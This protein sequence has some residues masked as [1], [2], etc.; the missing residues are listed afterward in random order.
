M[1]GIRNLKAQCETPNYMRESRPSRNQDRDPDAIRA[2]G[3]GP[4]RGPIG[5]PDNAGVMAS[6]F[7]DLRNIS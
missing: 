2:E 6:N 7:V 3:R 1:A 5:I 4:R